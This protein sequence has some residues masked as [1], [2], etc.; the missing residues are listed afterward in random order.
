MLCKCGKRME[1]ICLGVFLCACGCSLESGSTGEWKE[2]DWLKRM[3]K[4]FNGLAKRVVDFVL[5]LGKEK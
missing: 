2:E 3:D 1:A 5:E 4:K